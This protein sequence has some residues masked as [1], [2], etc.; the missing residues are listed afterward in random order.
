M[1]GSWTTQTKDGLATA[2]G[3]PQSMF[4]VASTFTADAANASVPNLPIIDNPSAFLTDIG[5]KFGT[6]APDT[7]TITITDSDG[8][9]VY[10]ES[11]ITASTRISISERPAV[12]NGCTVAI[13]GNTT[14][15]ATAKVILYFARNTRG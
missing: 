9:T 6:T 15:S 8:L 13:S 4:S 11:S 3:L 1:A 7:V 12:L 2:G 14:N 10:T 5:I